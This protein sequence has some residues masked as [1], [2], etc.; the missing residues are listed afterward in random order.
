MT[1]RTEKQYKDI[2]KERRE[3]IMDSAL[4]VF[5]KKGYHASSVAQIAKEA[6]ISKGLIY[7]YFDSKEELLKCILDE[8]ISMMADMINPNNDDEIT[9]EEMKSFFDSM[10]DSMKTNREHWVILFQLSMQKDVISLLFSNQGLGSRNE[11]TM[12]LAYKYFAERFEK[13]QEELLFFR[14]VLKGFALILVLTPH[15]CSDDMIDSMKKRLYKL[16]IKP[17]AN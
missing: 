16:F 14:S 10:I 15:M 3:L 1:P 5:S 2:R 4:M 11:K 8:F 9:T 6:G 13:P 12:Q 17:K 7:N